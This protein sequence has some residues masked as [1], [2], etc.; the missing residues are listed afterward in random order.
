MAEIANM[1]T[2]QFPTTQPK[3]TATPAFADLAA[4]LEKLGDPDQAFSR[5]MDAR[6]ENPGAGAI[7]ESLQGLDPATLALLDRMGS[8]RQARSSIGLPMAALGGLLGIAPYEAFKGL[9]QAV[10]SVGQPILR[11]AGG[12]TGDPKASANYTLDKTSSPASLQNVL[13]YF[14]GLGLGGG[15]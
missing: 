11:A 10:P 12:A 7:T 4:L 14:Y 9:A 5:V 8:A 1:L 13:A 3:P 6:G 15:Q 2:G